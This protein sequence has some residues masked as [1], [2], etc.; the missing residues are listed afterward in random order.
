[1]FRHT[2]SKYRALIA[3]TTL[4][5]IGRR[6]DASCPIARL[7]AGRTANQHLKPEAGE[8]RD[9]GYEV[10]PLL[11]RSTLLADNIFSKLIVKFLQ[12]LV[13]TPN[14]VI[15]CSAGQWTVEQ[16]LHGRHHVL[17]PEKH[18]DSLVV[19][20]MAKAD[21]GS[22]LQHLIEGHLKAFATS[23]EAERAKSDALR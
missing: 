12:S 9:T 8:V 17:P 5:D 23:H 10:H 14:L 1:M 2:T 19:H 20:N 18:N 15:R 13:S 22:I 7:E 6:G 16:R 21:T 4:M 3:R 11:S